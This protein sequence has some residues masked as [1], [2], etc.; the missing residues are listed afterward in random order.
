MLPYR[1][2]IIA[3]KIYFS[4]FGSG[5]KLTTSFY[6]GYDTATD[7]VN[8]T[9]TYTGTSYKDYTIPINMVMDSFWTKLTFSHT[10]PTA[11]AAI[12]RKVEVIYEP[13]DFKL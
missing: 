11:T 12:V 2:R 13:T 8:N 5:A 10:S 9:L 1:A 7:L 6:Q 3:I 4:Q